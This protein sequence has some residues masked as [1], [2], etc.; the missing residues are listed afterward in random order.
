MIE[1]YLLAGSGIKIE[2]D[3][4][5]I[6]AN[7]LGYDEDFGLLLSMEIIKKGVTLCYVHEGFYCGIEEI[8]D[9]IMRS[10]KFRI[11]IDGEEI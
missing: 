3:N 5:V 4:E 2:L 6:C 11:F 10:N 1:K 7:V 8:N 9:K